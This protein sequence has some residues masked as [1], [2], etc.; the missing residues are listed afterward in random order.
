MSLVALFIY[1]ARMFSAFSFLMILFC[2]SALAFSAYLLDS[3]RSL[4]FIY[5]IFIAFKSNSISLSVV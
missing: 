5:E 3:E 1:I 4:F 2:L